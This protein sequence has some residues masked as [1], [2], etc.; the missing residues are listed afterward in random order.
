M[1][2][3]VE[4]Q[5]SARSRWHSSANRLSSRT[6][7]ARLADQPVEAGRAGAARRSRPPAPPAGW[8]LQAPLPP[9][10]RSSS[11][12]RRD[13][14]VSRWVV[15]CRREASSC[16]T[17]TP[18]CGNWVDQVEEAVLGDPQG[19][20]RRSPRPRSRCA[21]RRTGSR[22]RRRCRSCSAGPPSPARAAC[23][24]RCRRCRPARYRRHRPARPGGTDRPPATNSTCSLVNASS[25]SLAGSILANSGIVRRTSTSCW[26]GHVRSL[27]VYLRRSPAAARRHSA[28]SCA[29]A[30]RSCPA[31]DQRDPRL[32]LDQH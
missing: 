2:A 17:S 26:Q 21:A 9:A 13:A 32:E 30:S 6:A 8:P 23:R 20:E 28:A 11:R 10:A 4:R 27:P 5:A 31:S 7:A 18:T 29:C 3:R 19:H 1:V 16:M 22:S 14:S 24:P 12:S 15:W 25:L